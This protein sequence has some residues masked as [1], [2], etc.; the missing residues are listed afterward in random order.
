[1]CRL[2]AET[3]DKVTSL[4]EPTSHTSEGSLLR[5]VTAYD[6]IDDS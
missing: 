3:Q 6:T 4:E 2:Q 5:L 1:M